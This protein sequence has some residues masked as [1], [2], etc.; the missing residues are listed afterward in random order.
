MVFFNGDGE[1]PSL[2]WVVTQPIGPIFKDSIWCSETSVNNY[3]RMLR[4]ISEERRSL[5]YRDGSLKSR[6]E[7]GRLL[8][9]TS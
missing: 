3:Q 7:M 6:V 5:L 2:F 4:N 9:G 8:H 1:R